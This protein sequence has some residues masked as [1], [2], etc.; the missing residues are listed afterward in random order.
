MPKKGRS[1]ED[2]LRAL[3]V[4]EAGEA[5]VAACR[6]DGISQQTLYVWKKRCAGLGLS[7]LCELRQ[8]REENAK[9]K[10]L[11]ADLSLDCHTLQASVGRRGSS[12]STG[13]RRGTRPHRDSQEAL[14]IRLRE[15]AASR[16]RG[17]CRLPGL[18]RREGWSGTAKRSSRLDPKDGLLGRTKPRKRAARR[19]RLPQIPVRAPNR[20]WAMDFVHQRL[21]DGRW[22]RVLTVFDQ[23]TRECLRLVAD[24]SLSGQKVAVVLEPLVHCRRA[25]Q[26]I[27]VDS[28]AEFAS[29]A[30]DVWAAQH[31]VQLNVLR[32]GKPV[33]NGFIELC[34][35]RLRDKCLNVEV[36]FS[37][38]DARR[39][40]ERWREDY[41]R[42]R[43]HSALQDRTPAEVAARWTT[44]ALRELETVPV[45]PDSRMLAETLS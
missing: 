7:E 12:G 27:T 31:G 15:L 19:Q 8:L 18:R 43:P 9:L 45:K 32:P 11:V 14:R 36:F 13:P 10:R 26:A 34:T 40:L 35:G 17:A 1:E 23:A 41:N 29:R 4:V 38:V 37:L 20:R 28:C 3:H 2:M 44:V 25:P 6:T 39:K 21:V 30:L 5:G 42:R 33:E 24:S 16:V 22:F